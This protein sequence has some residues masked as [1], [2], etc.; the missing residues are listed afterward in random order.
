MWSTGGVSPTENS[1]TVQSGERTA[2]GALQRARRDPGARDQMNAALFVVLCTLMLVWGQQ[3]FW[4]NAW[5]GEPVP[6]WLHMAPVLLAGLASLRRR[7]STGVSLSLSALALAGDAALGGSTVLFVILVDGLYNAARF[8]GPRLRRA[9]F[10]LAA[11]GSVLAAALNTAAY[12]QDVPFAWSLMQFAALFGAPIWWGTDLRQKSEIAELAEDRLAVERARAAD[13][14]RIALL[15]RTEAVQGERE[16]MAG[17]LHD[18]IASR[19][20]AIALHSAAA[21]AAG[22]AGEAADSDRDR[23]ALQL[24]RSSSIAALED[25]RS[26][27]TVLRSSAHQE[28]TDGTPQNALDRVTSAVSPTA[29]IESVR[30]LADAAEGLG[31]PVRVQGELPH[32]IPAS[33]GQTLYR[34]VQESLTNVLKHAPG[35][36]ADISFHS[37][38]RSLELR[39]E[40]DLSARPPAL[41][42]GFAALS[43]G[44]GLEIM[45]ARTAASGGHLDV[46]A[47]ASGRAW[48]VRATF[49]L[50]TEA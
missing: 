47:S 10:G 27:I 26:M 31:V 25:M 36:A 5:N 14:E 33:L 35:S 9:V 3:G 40:N 6:R 16:R 22:T 43:S 11:F 12:G 38:P 49:P 24:A 7:R 48:S 8:A 29:S 50:R 15:D 39:I 32:G 1:Q 42:E 41:P 18:A 2:L 4:G 20:S 17:D 45:R 13:R 30:A 23:A 46:G 28:V 37:S 21:L 34:I 19:L 44:A